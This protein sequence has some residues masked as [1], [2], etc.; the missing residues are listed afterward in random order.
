MASI[1]APSINDLYSILISPYTSIDTS[2]FASSPNQTSNTLQ[3][4][5]ITY[6]INANLNP[7]SANAQAQTD[8]VLSTLLFSEF[9]QIPKWQATGLY[10]QY[11]NMS[12]LL[13]SNLNIR[14]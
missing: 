8:Y 12:Y 7:D 9:G 4:Q 11:Q 6:L 1:S 13:D 10:L 14:V 3:S 2:S 5:P